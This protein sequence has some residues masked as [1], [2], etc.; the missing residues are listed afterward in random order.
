MFGIDNDQH[1]NIVIF[2]PIVILICVHRFL[3]IDTFTQTRLKTDYD[4]LNRIYKL[5]SLCKT[6]TLE[7]VV[8]LTSLLDK[9]YAKCEFADCDCKNCYKKESGLGKNDPIILNFQAVRTYEELPGYFT[10][11]W[12]LRVFRI[13]IN[14]IARKFGKC[15]EVLM[16]IAQ[17][18]Y[19]YLGNHYYA[20]VLIS[21]IE[22]RCPPLLT[23]LQLFYIRH[24][25]NV[26]LLQE[27]EKSEQLLTALEYQ[28]H[29]KK[30]LKVADEI[31]ENTVK[32]WAALLKDPPDMTIL[33]TIG[34]SLF[35]S[36][37]TLIKVVNEINKICANNIEFLVKYGLYMKAIVNDTYSSSNAYNSIM[38]SMDR[39]RHSRSNEHTFSI[40]QSEERNMMIVVSLESK[41]NMNIIDANSE[42]EIIL[43]ST[44]TELIGKPITQIMPPMI[45][46]IHERCMQQFFKTMVSKA[47]N[48][49]H[50][51]LIR[52]RDGIYTFCSILKQ[53]VPRLTNGFCGIMFAHVDKKIE[54]FMQ[55]K[56][57]VTS[58]R[59]GAIICDEFMK[60]IG[61]NSEASTVLQI[62]AN[63]LCEVANK[64][65]IDMIFPET[66]SASN[67]AELMEP[68]GRV[69]EFRGKNI[70]SDNE[71]DDTPGN[72]TQNTG[73]L[74]W[75]RLI[76]ETYCDIKTCFIM[77]FAEIS[78]KHKPKYTRI[79]D[80]KFFRNEER[81]SNKKKRFNIYDDL[82]KD[83]IADNQKDAEI[84]ID[85]DV[86]FTNTISNSGSASSTNKSGSSSK[87]S[88]IA[89]EMLDRALACETPSSIKKLTGAIII[90]YLV[91]VVLVRIFLIVN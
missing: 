34:V 22:S 32:F 51:R 64:N 8:T 73:I 25:I 26:G 30:F 70:I 19:F 35:E 31:A 47:L 60:I 24:I 56:K 50:L 82:K 72:L 29:F 1:E 39:I 87:S 7:G 37:R 38:R 16:L 3:R 12:K 10:Q 78:D 76:K 74:M 67:I 80:S 52:T 6:D 48:I 18:F 46:E 28:E 85:E 81:T 13:L 27:A 20:L 45:G 43:N 17:I 71:I 55:A 4:A 91:A 2:L 84:P 77:I 75:V 90:L 53:I 66:D 54:Q 15:D 68:A 14:D 65:S 44:R 36:R 9:H 79:P 11:T 83:L 61:F 62:P 33:N 21:S 88:M 41:D 86:C 59:I 89:K 57:D 40:L 5:I 23:K 58:H 42:A 49:P 69:L 63:I